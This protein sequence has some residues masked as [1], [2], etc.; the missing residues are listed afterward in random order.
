MASELAFLFEV[1]DTEIDA[2]FG[3]YTLAIGKASEERN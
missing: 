1:A 2:L 3:V